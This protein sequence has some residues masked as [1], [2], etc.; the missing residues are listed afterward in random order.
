MPVLHEEGEVVYAST[1]MRDGHLHIAVE[2]VGG[3]TRAGR[4]VQLMRDSP[5][6]DTRIEN[7]AGRLADRV[8]LPSFLLAAGVLAVTRN[9]TRAA[10]ILITDF[11][12]GI[13]VSVPTAVLATM[14]SAAQA[15]VVIRSGRALEQLAG[16]DAVVFDKTG[17]ITRG[18]PAVTGV[19]S[20]SSDLSDDDV[21]AIA[22]TADQ[23][24]NHP[25]RRQLSIT[26][27]PGA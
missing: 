14:T 27:R 3:E 5:V 9:P 26:R 22:A 10:S 6:H 1:L 15:G 7:Y 19:R 2:Q 11:A 13:R 4:I 8:V 20:M 24:L 16:V 21:L 18:D 17:T 23:R 25:V 12:T